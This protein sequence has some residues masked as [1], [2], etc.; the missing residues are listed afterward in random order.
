MNPMKN[1]VLIIIFALVFAA[2]IAGSVLV[3]TAPSKNTV[4]VISDGEI[5]YTF[6]LRTAADMTLRI[7][8]DGNSNTIEIRDHRIRVLSADCPDQ[9]CVRMGWLSSSAMPI[10]C[11]PHHLVITFADSVDGI[12]AVTG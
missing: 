1:K 8:D 6:D 7:G 3:M 11:L 12:D 4:H 5:L 10:V 2:G 9:T